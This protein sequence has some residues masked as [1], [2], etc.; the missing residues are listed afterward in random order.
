MHRILKTIF[1][2][3]VYD[4]SDEDTNIDTMGF[5]FAMPNFFTYGM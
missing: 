3:G 1:V 2:T 5:D 4:S